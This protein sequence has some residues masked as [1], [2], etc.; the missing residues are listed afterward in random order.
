MEDKEREL[1]KSYLRMLDH[2]EK[3][4]LC[5]KRIEEILQHMFDETIEKSRKDLLDLL[6]KKAVMVK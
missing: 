1:L 5:R 3:C 4:Q 6:N 2:V